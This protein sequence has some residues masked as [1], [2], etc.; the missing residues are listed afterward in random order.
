MQQAQRGPA[1][2][3]QITPQQE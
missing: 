2:T 1:I 3:G